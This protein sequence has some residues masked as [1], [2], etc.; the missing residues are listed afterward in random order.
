MVLFGCRFAYPDPSYLKRVL[1]EL[2][3]RGVTLESA[4]DPQEYKEF[5]Q[6]FW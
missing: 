5:T 4:D 6:L 2:T 3:T 1:E